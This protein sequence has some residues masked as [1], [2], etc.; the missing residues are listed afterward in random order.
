MIVNRLG[1]SFATPIILLG[2][3]ITLAG[4]TT[5]FENQILGVALVVIGPFFWSSSYGSQI[6][7]VNQQFRE[8]N[9]FY[10]IKSGEWKPLDKLPDISVI[11]SKEG[12][13]VFSRSNRSSSYIEDKFEVCLLNKTHRKRMTVQK[14]D[15]F[16]HAKTHAQDLAIKLKKELVTFNPKVSEKT[17]NRRMFI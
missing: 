11:K 4:I 2:V 6:D 8:Y 17:R 16:E 14:F 9:S 13:T 7:T 1:F 5:L 15:T 3:V 12:I 10:G